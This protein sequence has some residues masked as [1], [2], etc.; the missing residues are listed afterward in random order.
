M[1]EF[2]PSSVTVSDTVEVSTGKFSV[3][4]I[5]TSSHIEPEFF[6]TWIANACNHKKFHSEEHS[7]DAEWSGPIHVRILD[8]RRSPLTIWTE[9]LIGYHGASA[10]SAVCRI[11][12]KHYHLNPLIAHE[13]CWRQCMCGQCRLSSNSSRHPVS[14]EY[15]DP[16]A[17]YAVDSSWNQCHNSLHTQKK[18]RTENL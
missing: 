11:Q 10:C 6:Q 14:T 8:P 7:K 18:L 4:S 9:C 5:T 13:Q 12:G 16:T 17:V 3:L 1:V 2:A 15:Q